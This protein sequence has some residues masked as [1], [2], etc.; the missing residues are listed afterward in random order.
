MPHTSIVIPCFNEADRL[1]VETFKTFASNHAD[2]HFQFVDD[3]S[4]DRT[5]EVLESLVQTN[6]HTFHFLRLEKNSGKGEAVRQGVL[7]ALRTSPA[8]VGYWDADLSTSLDEIPRFIETMQQREEL[9]AVI[10]SRVRSLGRK[11][12][13]RML[14]HYVG[15]VFATLAALTLGLGV[16]DTQC[17][18]KLFRVTDDLPRLFE[19]PFQSRWVFD[20]ELLARLRKLAPDSEKGQFMATILELPLL[21]WKDVEGSKLRLH[22]AIGGFL[23][24]LRIRESYPPQPSSLEDKGE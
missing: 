21:A 8:L 20:V 24:L 17:G 22:H 11:I 1:D 5:T 4:A 15:R 18:A 2:I 13:R 12:E 9:V 14:R 3:G 16:Y 10:G 7:E 23:D 19:S 6:P